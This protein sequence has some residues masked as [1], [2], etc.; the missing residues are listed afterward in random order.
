MSAEDGLSGPGVAG[1]FRRR[2]DTRF[3]AASQTHAAENP[4]FHPLLT[5][6]EQAHA[7]VPFGFDAYLDFR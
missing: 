2:C 7:I 5:N 3:P 6:R 4:D 1:G